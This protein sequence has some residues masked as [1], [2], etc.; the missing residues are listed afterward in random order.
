MIRCIETRIYNRLWTL[1]ANFKFHQ[2]ILG[3]KHQSWI[4]WYMLVIYDIA[5]VECGKLSY[6]PRELSCI[7][8]MIILCISEKLN[9]LSFCS[10]SH[11][12][13]RSI[14]NI[15]VSYMTVQYLRYRSNEY[16]I[17]W[18][19]EKGKSQMILM[20]F[21]I[22]RPLYESIHSSHLY[23]YEFPRHTRTQKDLT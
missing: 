22:G 8:Y 9:F 15:V 2:L 13:R 12:N 18:K 3:L 16:K 10:K 11:D 5:S 1:N 7:V 4:G 19:H 17:R 20:E 23:T 6:A 14:E 21:D